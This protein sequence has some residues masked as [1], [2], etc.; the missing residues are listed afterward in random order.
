MR[1]S[2]PE[3]IQRLRDRL[4]EMRLDGLLVLNAA[5]RRYISGYLAEDTSCDES[6]GALLISHGQLTLAT[7]GRYVLQARQEAQ[8]FQVQAYRKGLEEVLPELLMAQG[9]NRLGF[10]SARISVRQFQRLESSLAAAACP[11]T[12]VPTDGAVEDL[13]QIKDEAEIVATR[14]AVACAERAF[15]ALLAWLRPGVTERA[16]ARR[17]EEALVAEGAEGPSFPI[18][19][20][21]GPNSALPHAQP[22]ERK[23]RCGEPL[24]FDWGARLEGYCSDISRTVV[25]G[26]PDAR[27]LQIFAI[28]A[29][30]QSRAVSAMATCASGREVDAVA[31][32]HIAA[33][34]FPDAFGHSLGHGT[35]LA[36][37]EAPRLSPHADDRLQPG[38]IVTVEPGIYLEGW[39]GVRLENQV[40]ITSGGP[41]ILN[42]L[43]L[44]IHLPEAAGQ[45][46]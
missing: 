36:I 28:V 43:P 12:L 42:R 4:P 16:I 46:T 22:G 2:H 33:A 6:A 25:L 29:E 38:M 24:L 21:S 19:V 41:E 5:N 35:G 27:F 26:A 45:A 40:L 9:L 23:V 31:R 11:A 15:E 7:D 18:I 37:H 39:G 3:R 32:R 20:A 44:A 1:P 17:L 8:G 13:R 34:G 14:N 30:A 10:E